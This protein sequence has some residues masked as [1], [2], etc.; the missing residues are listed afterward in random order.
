VAEAIAEYTVAGELLAAIEGGMTT[1]ARDVRDISEFAYRRGEVSFVEF[2]DAQR[3]FN[4]T[5][6]SYHEAMARYALARYRIDWVT[7]RSLEP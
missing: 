6:R 3:A 5:M 1:E 4:E 7:G 2:L